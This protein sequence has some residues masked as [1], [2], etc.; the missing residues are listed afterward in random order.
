MIDFHDQLTEKI[1][2]EKKEFFFIVLIVSLIRDSSKLRLNRFV[3]ISDPL[4]LRVV[5]LFKQISDRVCQREHRMCF[6]C[7]ALHSWKLIPLT[8]CVADVHAFVYACVYGCVFACIMYI[9][10]HV[11]ISLTFCK[12]MNSRIF[13]NKPLGATEW[14]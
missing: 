3:V 5:T 11:N 12:G 7:V 9:P 2:V 4:V 14:N 10:I 6:R 8:R 1:N 13:Y